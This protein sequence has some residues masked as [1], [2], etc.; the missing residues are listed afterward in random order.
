MSHQLRIGRH[1]DNDIVINF[2]EVSS[3]HAVLERT[4]GE[5]YVLTDIGSTNGSFVNGKRIKKS[6]VN[7][8]DEIKLAHYQISLE[9]LL[10]AYKNKEVIAQKPDDYSEAFNELKNVYDDYLRK[11][12]EV[13]KTDKKTTII[14][15]VLAFI[16][17]VGSGLGQISSSLSDKQ[18][19]LLLL[20]EDFKANYCCPKCCQFLGNV[21]WANLARRNS[22]MYCKTEWVKKP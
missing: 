4:E 1:R 9:R 19:K 5:K 20:E 3:F 21:P 18:E 22:C 7:F 10:S 11:K 15:G 6:L 13:M 14:K 17:Y 8:K 2:P 16:P 12:L